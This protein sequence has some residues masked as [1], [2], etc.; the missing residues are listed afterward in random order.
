M[1]GSEGGEETDRF[2]GQKVWVR[3][4]GERTSERTGRPEGVQVSGCGVSRREE[5]VDV[6]GVER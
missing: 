5:G 3:L 2:T 4:P 6:V 1:G